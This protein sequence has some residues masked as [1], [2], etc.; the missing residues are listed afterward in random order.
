MPGGFCSVLGFG[1]KRA[2]LSSLMRLLRSQ[3]ALLAAD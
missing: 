3:L 2:L 1:V